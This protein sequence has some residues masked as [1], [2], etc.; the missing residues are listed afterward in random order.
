MSFVLVILDCVRPDHVGCYGYRRGT[1]P[2][3]D[4]F[5]GTATRFDNAITAGVWTL[6]SMASMMTG[7]YPSQHGLN[8]ADRALDRDLVTLPQRLAGAGWRTAGFTANPHGGRT[9]E[10]DRGFQEFHEFWGAPG[11]DH[12]GLLGR[13][14]RWARPRLRDAV[15][16]SQALTVTARRLQRHRAEA[17][18]GS[19]SRLA[20]A[21]AAW[22]RQVRN[23]GQPFFALVHL[24]ESHVP[25][26][27]AA[28]H[29]ER[30][31]DEP[32]RRRVAKLDH[33]GMGYLAGVNPLSESDLALIGSLYDATISYGDELVGRVLDAVGDEEDTLV[34]I[35]ADHGQQLGEHR[36]MGHFFSVYDTLARVPLVLRHPQ[37]PAGVVE[38]PVQ[39]VDL[40]PTVLEAA[41]LDP[42]PGELC[43]VSLCARGDHRPVLVT[44]YL[45]PDLSRFARFRGFDPAPFDREL[46]ALRH[47]GWKYIWSS[48]GREQLYDLAGDPGEAR[49]LALHPAGAE[50][51][52]DFRL[53]HE[54]WQAEMRR[55]AAGQRAEVAL[56]GD[57]AASLRALGYFD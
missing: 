18:G 10:L 45:E 56:E 19:G 49:D 38:R 40:Y 47:G 57:V 15:K 50:R 37:L 2:N 9:F 8:R 36:M 51:L 20:D 27:P 34:A 5:A 16:R 6:P 29:V 46:R 30:F 22:I 1:T 3:L 7:L 17:T 41:G 24:M 52:G 32:G 26:T 14:Y 11:T 39:S 31:L 25:Y 4:G 23:T 21:A 42:E 12:G 43:A 54:Q 48:D 28:E 33:D 44:E 53:L 13:G 55:H 35:T